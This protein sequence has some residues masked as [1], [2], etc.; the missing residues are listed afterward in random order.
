MP[1]ICPASVLQSRGFVPKSAPWGGK[2]GRFGRKA[3]GSFDADRHDSGTNHVLSWTKHRIF[4]TLAV[5]VGRLHLY[6]VAPVRRSGAVGH[7]APH[8]WNTGGPYMRRALAIS[9]VD[10]EVGAMLLEKLSA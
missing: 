1:W 4:G 7:Q 2:Q 9:E 10:N 3:A 8:D 5:L 6:R